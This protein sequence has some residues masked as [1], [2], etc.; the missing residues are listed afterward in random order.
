M[1]GE[2]QCRCGILPRC[3]RTV[4]LLCILLL[5]GMAQANPAKLFREGNKAY[6]AGEF[7]AAINAYLEAT[8]ETTGSAEIY[9]NL[10][11]AQYRTELFEEAQA[12]FEFAASL[13]ETDALRSQCWYNMAN[14]LVKTAETFR[15]NEPQAAVQY[16]RQAAWLY[17]TALSYNSSFS[18]AAYN[19]EISQR[20]AASIVE[21]IREQEEKE[22]QENELIKYIREKLEEFIERQSNLIEAKDTGPAQKVLEKETRE[23]AKVMEESGLH[24]DIEFPDGSLVPGPLKE[25]YEHTLKAAKAMEVPDQHTALVELMEALGAAPDDPDQQDGESDEDSEDYEDYDM[26][27][28]ESDEDA[29]MYE[30]ADPFGDFSEYEEIRGVPPPNQTE[31]DILAEELLN[32]ERR[33]E[34]KAGEYK[35][36]E[37]DW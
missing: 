2:R 37:K 12:S 9:Y 8:A 3:A 21:E 10:G 31:M 19:L 30:E 13:A 18:D 26:D 15:E 16:C 35:S 7:D 29:D 1:R 4:L 36:V 20:I 14:C 27:Y 25:T 28:E 32:Q 24:T 22:Q 17:R 34:K 6:A 33:K 23:L 11:N 5:G